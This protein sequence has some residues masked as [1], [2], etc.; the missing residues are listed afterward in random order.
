MKS[1][2]DLSLAGKERTQE[3]CYVATRSSILDVAAEEDD[4]VDTKP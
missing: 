2:E 3:T 1:F 4:G